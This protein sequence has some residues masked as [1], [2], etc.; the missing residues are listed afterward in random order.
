ML[1]R[2]KKS[3]PGRRPQIVPTELPVFD[4]LERRGLVVVMSERRGKK[5]ELRRPKKPAR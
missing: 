2:R 4:E 5:T 3:K 1:D